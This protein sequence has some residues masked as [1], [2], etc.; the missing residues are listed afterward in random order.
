LPAFAILATASLLSADAAKVETRGT[1]TVPLYRVNVIARTTK[2]VNYPRTGIPIPIDFRG[3]VLLPDSRG[4]AKV[5][6]KKGSTEIKAKFRDLPPPTRFGNEY[7]TY[8]LWAIT[9]EGRAAN[10]GQI[11]TDG[12]DKGKLQA[13]T[14]LQS[15]ALIVTA[16]PYFAVTHPSNVVVMENIVRPDTRGKIEEVEAKYH[17]LQRGE[18]Q[19]DLTA[20]ES[21]PHGS[22]KKL[23]LDQYEALLEIYQA[24]NA[25]QIAGALGGHRYAGDSLRKAEDLLQQ[26]KDYY[27]GKADAKTVV[28]TAR[29]AAQT[30]EDARLIAVRMRQEEETSTATQ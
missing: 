30:A 27:S 11:L 29:Q 25:V 22:R 7:L 15:F 26:A 17:L 2:A 18:Y 12:G 16:E 9:P 4:E 14:E 6:N 24:Q 8:V 13:T 23:P 20:A 1:D 21:T 10:L 3:T 5:E 19:Y 28:M